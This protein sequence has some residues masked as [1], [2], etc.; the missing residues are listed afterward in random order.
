MLLATAGWL[1]GQQLQLSELKLLT[2]RYNY[3]PQHPQAVSIV[4]AMAGIALLLCDACCTAM[5]WSSIWVMVAVLTATAIFEWL[6]ARISSLSLMVSV[7]AR[8]A[9]VV[10]AAWLL[11]VMQVQVVAPFLLSGL[12]LRN[13]PFGIVHGKPLW[14][15]CYMRRSP[16][17]AIVQPRS[18]SNGIGDTTTATQRYSVLDHGIMPDTDEDMIDKLQALIDRVGE[19][20]GGVVYFPRG[21]YLFNKHGRK[22]FLQ[23]N[24]S[25][26]TLEGEVDSTGRLLTELV[27]CGTT[28]EGRRNPWLSPAFITTGEALQPS[29]QFWGLDFRKPQRVHR[30]SSSLSDP[31]SDGTILTPPFST[32]VVASAQAG[33][34]QLRVASSAAVGR[35]VMLGM[36][37]TTPDG[38]LLKELLGVETFR[39]EWLTAHRAGAEEAPSFQWL[40]EVVSKPDA[41]TV[42]LAFPL[43]RDCPLSFEPALFNVEM[44]EDVHIRNLHLTSRWNGLFRHH[45]FPLYYSVAQT[46]EMDYGWNAISL[47]RAAHSSVQNVEI[48]DFSNPLYVHDSHQCEVAHVRICGY[49]GHQGLKMYCHTSHCS[50]HHIDFFCHYADMMGGEGNAYANTFADIRYLSSTFK[51]VDYDFHGFSE[52]PMAPPAWNT[53]E[54]IEGFRLIK[55]AGAVF[56]LPACAVCN[57]WVSTVSEGERRGEPIFFAMNYRARSFVEKYVVAMGYTVVMSLKHRNRGGAFLLQTF[58]NKV[59]DIDAMSV[60]CDEHKQ[61]FR[62][63]MISDITTTAVVD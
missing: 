47:R 58:R 48:S 33:D 39:Q 61:F 13:T 20:G 21:R 53:F 45:G 22:A 7:C 42:E 63:T 59:A 15:A 31:G 14:L 6:L 50:F 24:H 4:A 32:R 8:C 43:L 2:L 10:L 37:N 56:N 34:R 28:V 60:P 26:I 52:G 38:R 9:A 57:R 35:Y 40:V 49:D 1:I 16:M 17:A 46:Q 44:L 29:N 25:H 41:H 51:P 27:C 3:R 62:Q 11:Y 5:G 30:E 54:R 12:Y 23:I 55:G 18:S 36:Y 19:S